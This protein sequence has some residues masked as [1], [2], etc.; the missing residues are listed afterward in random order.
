MG[1]G[2]YFGGAYAAAGME[3]DRDYFR[4]SDSIEDRMIMNVKQ[5]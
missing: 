1:M 5:L 2:S 4:Y 3:I